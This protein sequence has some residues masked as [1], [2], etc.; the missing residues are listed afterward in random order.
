MLLNER[1]G[2]SSLGPSFGQLHKPTAQAAGLQ[3]KNVPAGTQ[4]G[5]G[6]PHS[7]LKKRKEAARQAGKIGPEQAWRGNDCLL[8]SSGLCNRTW[9]LLV[10]A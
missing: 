1:R 10:S 4:E 2:E 7:V 8:S 5:E 9:A 6:M 3:P